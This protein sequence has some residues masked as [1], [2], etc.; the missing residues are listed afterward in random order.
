MEALAGLAM[1]FVPP[2]ALV[3]VG[4]VLRRHG[5]APRWVG[6]LLTVVG[7]VG[8]LLVAAVE[9]WLLTTFDPS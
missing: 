5:A 8:L 9:A 2:V 4:Q 3:I 1:P 7:V 6:T